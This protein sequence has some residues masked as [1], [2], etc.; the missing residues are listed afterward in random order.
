MRQYSVDEFLGRTEPCPLTEQID[1]KVSVLYDLYV[2]STQKGDAD[3]RETA[4]RNLLAS[5]QTE[6]QID[7]ALHDVVKGN[8]TIDE[9]LTR[10]GYLQ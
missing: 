10:K 2:L 8:C 1:K 7:N 6:R 9:L 5:Y 4:V 3:W